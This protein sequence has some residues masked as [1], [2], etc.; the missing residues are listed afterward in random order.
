MADIEKVE[1]TFPDQQKEADEAAEAKKELEIEVIDDTPEV[2][3][4]R[5]P[6]KT[7]PK[8]LT[9]D[10]LNKY[11]E[12]VK[13]RIKHFSKG[14]HDERRAKEAA[15]REQEEAFKIARAL[16]EENKRLRG[17]LGEGQE[18]LIGQAKKV[19]ANEYEE[20]K[21]KYKEATEAFDTDAQ[22]AAQEEMMAVRIRADKL[23]N[24]KPA[25][26]QPSEF[27]VQTEQRAKKPQ[28][29]EKLTSWQDR[30]QW[31]GENKRMTAYALGLHED[32]LAEGIPA[33]SDKYYEK[34]DADLRQRF[35]DQ[36]DGVEVDAKPQ[37]RRSNVVAPATRSTA[38]RK[39]VL[40]KSQVNTA[41]R[42]GVS[43]ELYARKVAELEGR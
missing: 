11:D 1:Y 20:A 10:E 13:T 17:S 8:D 32:L 6:L 14:Y 38:A 16:V 12:S 22:I 25:P 27:E 29:D 43:L 31:F 42:L 18:A 19:V 41:K 5:E 40:T 33:G 7:P 37:Q 4:G 39:V 34:L 30:N 3:R 28:L 2:D 35:P 26:L 21:R 23:E 24:F 15:L 9:D 36:F